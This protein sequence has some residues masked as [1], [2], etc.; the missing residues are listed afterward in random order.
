MTQISNLEGQAASR[1]ALESYVGASSRDLFSG[2]KT[3]K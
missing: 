3:Y 1:H 2:A